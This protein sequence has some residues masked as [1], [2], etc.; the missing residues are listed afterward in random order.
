ME[1]LLNDYFPLSE[2]SDTRIEICPG[3]VIKAQLL[4]YYKQ[5]GYPIVSA[6][7]CVQETGA[8]PL[9]NDLISD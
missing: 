6:F 5:K 7:S 3:K 1:Y 8:V 2:T 9:P 4:A